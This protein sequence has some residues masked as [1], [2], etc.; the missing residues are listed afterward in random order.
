MNP[1]SHLTKTSSTTSSV[2]PTDE[3]SSS[4]GNTEKMLLIHAGLSQEP[5]TPCVL[6][7]PNTCTKNSTFFY[8]IP[9]SMHT[10]TLSVK[11]TFII[12]FFKS[13]VEEQKIFWWF[14]G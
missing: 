11:T 3:H 14:Y 2:G 1:Q 4:M 8:E 10:T 9:N 12:N 13:A 5:T 7:T 6:N